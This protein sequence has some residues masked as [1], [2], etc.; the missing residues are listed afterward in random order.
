M[1]ALDMTMKSNRPR[2]TPTRRHPD[3]AVPR[4][5]G[6]PTRRHPDPAEVPLPVFSHQTKKKLLYFA[7]NLLFCLFRF[8]FL[9]EL[10]INYKL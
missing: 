6:T 10:F 1:N 9:S 3:P 5:G 4:P 8:N 7:F 2:G